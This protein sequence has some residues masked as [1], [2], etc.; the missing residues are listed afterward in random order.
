MKYLKIGIY[1]LYATGIIAFAAGLRVLLLAPGWPPT[2]SDEGTMAIMALNIAYRGEHPTIFYGQDYMGTLEAHLGAIFFRLAGGPSLFALR[3][4]VVLLVTLF[5]VSTYAL[6][7]L[8]FEKRLALVTLALLSVGSIPLLTRQTIA[9]GGSSQT[10]LFG[11]LAFLLATWLSLTYSRKPVRALLPWRIAGYCC[12]GL[13][14]GLG[15]WS[16]MVVVPFFV[17]AALLLLLC[18][19][20]ELL[21]TWLAILPCLFV[22]MLPLISYDQGQGLN[23]FGILLGLAHGSNAT[24][25]STLTGIIHNILA[26]VL[27]SIPTATG[28]PFCPVQ[29]QPWLGD[30]SPHTLHCTLV[31]AIWGG[32]YLLLLS[33][34][35]LHALRACWRARTDAAIAHNTAGR[36]QIVRSTARLLLAGGALLTI[37]LYTLSSGPVDQPGFHARYLVGLLI[38]TPALIAPL[39]SAASAHISPI[40]ALTRARTYVWR[41]ILVLLWGI[42]LGGTLIAFSEVP[43]AQAAQQRRSDLAAHLLKIKANHIYT[44]YWTCNSLAFASHERIICA[45]LDSNLQ[46]THNRA[47][48]YFAIVQADR[49]AAY[50]FPM[51]SS[52]LAAFERKMTQASYRRYTFDGYIVYQP[53]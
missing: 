51:G 39:W 43:A 3:L 40:S 26:T 1:E 30:S 37:V 52:Q 12:W 32:G 19:W 18:C 31:H 25:P 11:S 8:L 47:P 28:N 15:L 33:L 38:A 29:E 16:D 7:R 41:T 6:A 9:T 21:W 23:P 35:L 36:E 49:S 53:R 44:E 2:N 22:G 50:V 17:A 10:L 27:V 42:L 46:P 14:V 34:A 48:R 24:A 5:L 13:V 45:V 20:R 4:S